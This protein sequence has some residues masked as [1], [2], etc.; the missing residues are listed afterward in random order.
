M[1][2]MRQILI[3]IFVKIKLDKPQIAKIFLPRSARRSYFKNTFYRR[4][5][6]KNMR[7]NGQILTEILVKIELD[8]PHIAKIFSPRC[9]RHIITCSFLVERRHGNQLK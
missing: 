2:K 7:E 5:P 6:R 3:E 4:A 9:A 8:K 1:R